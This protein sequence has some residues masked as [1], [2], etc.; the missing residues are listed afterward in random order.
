MLYLAFRKERRDQGLSVVIDSRRQQPVPALL[1]SLSELQ[2]SQ[3]QKYPPTHIY[4][5]FRLCLLSQFITLTFLTHFLLFDLYLY[6][7]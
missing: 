2:V 3:P 5:V 1:S 6:G 4:R 7:S